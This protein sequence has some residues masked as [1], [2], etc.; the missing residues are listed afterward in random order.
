MTD[1]EYKKFYHFK[2]KV[3]EERTNFLFLKDSTMTYDNRFNSYYDALIDA[4]RNHGEDIDDMISLVFSE[5]IDHPIVKKKILQE[6][7]RLD[8]RDSLIKKLNEAN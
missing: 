5:Q 6:I 8:C 1:L 7:E 3:K 4:I 2:G